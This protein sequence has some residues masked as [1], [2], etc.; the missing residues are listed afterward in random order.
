MGFDDSQKDSETKIKFTIYGQNHLSLDIPNPVFK[1]HLIPSMVTA[2]YTR[3]LSSMFCFFTYMLDCG[4]TCILPK[5]AFLSWLIS[6]IVLFM[7]LSNISFARR[8]SPPG[9][10]YSVR[11]RE[12]GSRLRYSIGTP[13][14][15]P[16]VAGGGQPHRVCRRL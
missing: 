13:V 7:V 5:H 3:T 9:R 8:S 15:F 1:C 2:L 14:R 11:R 6:A 4:A 12:R 10:R 16:R